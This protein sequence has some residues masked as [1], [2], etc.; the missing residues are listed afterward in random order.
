VYI[1]AIVTAKHQ[2][3]GTGEGSDLVIDNLLIDAQHEAV[4][5]EA[6]GP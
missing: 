5:S 2:A 3:D 1:K 6:R 4:S